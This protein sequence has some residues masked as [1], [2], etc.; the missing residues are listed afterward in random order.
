MNITDMVVDQEFK[1][2]IPGLSQMEYAQLEQNIV[3]DG[4][5]REPI[6]I[7]KGHDIIV[8]GHNRY[9]I[10]QDHP[11]VE[12]SV[13]EKEFDSRDEV[14]AWMCANQLGRRNLSDAQR[15]ILLGQAYEARK[16]T[17]AAI[18]RNDAGQFIVQK[19]EAG[20]LKE[21]MAKEY[22][23][24]PSEIE[25]SGRYFRGLKEIEAVHPGTTDRIKS[26]DL[27]VTKKDVMSLTNIY[28]L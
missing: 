28:R 18:Q 11:E 14:I 23:A 1:N 27:E 26:G 20:R 8:D 4:V 13:Y 5:V 17:L 25:R 19:E 10:I 22:D 2:L 21:I 7:W 12:F 24:T 3:E 16:R 15:A 6:T 9:S